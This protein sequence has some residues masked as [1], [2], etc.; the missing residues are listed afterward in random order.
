MPRFDK[1]LQSRIHD[2]KLQGLIDKK[3]KLL[4][5]ANKQE[6]CDIHSV[7]DTFVCQCKVKECSVLKGKDCV[8]CGK[9]IW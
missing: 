2:L 5:D 1:Q 3:N 8:R 4:P 7:V 9:P 6:Q